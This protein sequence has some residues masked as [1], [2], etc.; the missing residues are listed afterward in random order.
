MLVR[1]VANVMQEFTQSGGVR[2]FGVSILIAGCDHNG[3][4]LYQV[5]PSGSFFPWKATAIGKY[6]K[7]A[8]A[9]LDKKF[10][11]DIEIEDAVHDALVVIKEGFEGQLTK[12]NIEIAIMT[13]D[14]P[15]VKLLAPNEIQDYL[16][17]TA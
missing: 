11:D 3:P 5:D 9:S 15:K 4:Q 6:Y 17:E 8:K 10:R 1:D 14:N 2:P 13:I 12:D 16:D 7:E